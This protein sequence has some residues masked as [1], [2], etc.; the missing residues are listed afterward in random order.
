MMPDLDGVN[1]GFS[2]CHHHS[3]CIR[4]DMYHAILISSLDNGRS[5]SIPFSFS[6]DHLTGTRLFNNFQGREFA[7]V[8]KEDHSKFYLL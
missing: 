5:R 7:I 1:P 6:S 4:R 3:P 2:L 8:Q